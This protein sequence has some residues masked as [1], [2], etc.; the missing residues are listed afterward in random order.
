MKL[1]N[2]RHPSEEVSF[3]QAVL[4]GL[5]RDQ[6]LFFPEAFETLDDLPGLLQT[7]FVERS[8][9]VLHRLVGDE[10]GEATLRGMVESAFDFPLTAPRLSDGSRAL[11]LFHGP[12]LA[13]KDFGA[14]FMARCLAGFHDGADEHGERGSLRA[15]GLVL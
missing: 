6:G 11:E 10:L 3:R 2:I 1:I 8:I 9:A 7:P 4:Q 13:F 15:A 12:S 14:R 5:G